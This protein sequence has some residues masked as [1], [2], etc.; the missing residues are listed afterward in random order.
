[1]SRY[2]IIKAEGILTL[3]FDVDTYLGNGWKL[4]GGPFV[5]NGEVCQAMTWEAAK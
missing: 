4:V 5:L 3:A 2:I 1:M